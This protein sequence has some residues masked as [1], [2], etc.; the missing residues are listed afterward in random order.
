MIKFLGI[1]FLGCFGLGSG[2]GLS[3]M[4]FGLLLMVYGLGIRVHRRG[5][6]VYR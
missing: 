2:F 3:F 4:N 1:D 6:G 5:F